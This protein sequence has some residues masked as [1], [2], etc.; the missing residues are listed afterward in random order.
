MTMKLLF[1]LSSHDELG[2]TGNKSG[3]WLEELATPYWCFREA[4]YVIQ[5]ASPRGGPAPLDPVSLKGTWITDAGQ[6]FLADEQARLA[7]KST[8]RFADIDATAL[9]A[10]FLV[11]GAATTWDFPEDNDLKRIVETLYTRSKLI[12]GICHGVIGLA[13]ASDQYGNPLV[14]NRMVTSISNEE[15]KLAGLDK[16]VPVLPE[17]ALRK[18]RALYSAAAPMA[19]NVVCDPPF[20]TGQNPASALSLARKIVAH[21]GSSASVQERARGK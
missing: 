12:A 3:N 4:G 17:D 18:A 21:Q 6:R 7:L 14:K 9:D 19:E 16:I 13:S 5:M 11:G 8:K 1:A 20:F 2:N 10:V 15:D